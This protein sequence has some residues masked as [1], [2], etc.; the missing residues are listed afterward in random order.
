VRAIYGKIG[1]ESRSQAVIWAMGHGFVPD[2]MR[3]TL[4]K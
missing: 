2:R 3:T 4:D 1:V